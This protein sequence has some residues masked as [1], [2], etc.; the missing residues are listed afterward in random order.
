[1]T[2]R[3]R[4]RERKVCDSIGGGKV[5]VG[6]RERGMVRVSNGAKITGGAKRFKPSRGRA[7][8]GCAHSSSSLPVCTATRLCRKEGRRSEEEKG[9]RERAKGA[10]SSGVEE[11]GERRETGRE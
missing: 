2:E 10:G 4:G 11:R 6:G 8:R 5:G 7:N 9:K 3:K 1:M